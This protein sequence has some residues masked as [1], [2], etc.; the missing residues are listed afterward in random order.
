MPTTLDRGSVFGLKESL[1][2]L[3]QNQADA[4]LLAQGCEPIGWRC[5]LCGAISVT[6]PS[7][8]ICPLCGGLENRPASLR[9]EML[10]LAEQNGCEVITLESDCMGPVGSVGCLLRHPAAG[11]CD[12]RRL[13][14]GQ[15]RMS[16]WN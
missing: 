10:C 11:E 9:E 5:A 7:V 16:S 14:R 8:N 4:L 6:V 1:R 12:D 3:V 13:P 15:R 2:A